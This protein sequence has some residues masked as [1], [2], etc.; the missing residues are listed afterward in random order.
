MMACQATPGQL[1]C[2]PFAMVGSI[3]VI[4]QSLNIQKTL[5]GYGI[6]PYIFRGGKMKN[7]VGMVGDVTRDGVVAMQQMIDRVHDAFRDHVASARGDAFATA[8]AASSLSNAIPKPCDDYFRL[9]A[10][11]DQRMSAQSTSIA[12]VMDQ[13]ATGDVFLGVEALKLGLVDRLITSDEYISER[14]QSGARVLKLINYRRP[15]GLSNLFSVPPYHHRMHSSSLSTGTD[16]AVRIL[17]KLV[18]RVTSALLAWADDGMTGGGS[19]LSVSSRTAVGEY[20]C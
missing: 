16:G 20:N 19:V 18:N 3:G 2:A 17:K 6:R 11:G 7:P 8:A 1:Y 15:T 5:E 10:G 12:H 9:S 14:I 4:G 13:V